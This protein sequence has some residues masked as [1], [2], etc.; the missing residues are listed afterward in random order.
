AAHTPKSAKASAK[1]SPEPSAKPSGKQAP[2]SASASA[3]TSPSKLR[4]THGDRVI[5]PA[6][7]LTKL[8]LVRYYE[9]VAEYIL[10]HLKG[11]PVSL[12]RAPSGIGGQTFF[13]KHVDPQQI[14]GVRELDPA[15]WPDHEALTEIASVQ[16]L[17]SAA[18]MHV[19]EFHTWNATTRR[20]DK[21]DR[22]IFD[23]DPEI[24]RAS[25]RERV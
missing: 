18:Q 11:R 9:S 1:S 3:K 7:G 12:V 25:C 10:P 8:D 21:P 2:A 13:Q 15:L 4:V 19:I 16:A 14:P 22:L 6:S 5:D 20:L 24:G 23:L 17:L